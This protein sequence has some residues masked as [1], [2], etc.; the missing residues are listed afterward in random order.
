MLSSANVT[1]GATFVV[2]FEIRIAAKVVGVRMAD[3]LQ[4]VLFLCTGNSARSILAECILNR[5][6]KGQFIAHSAGSDPKGVVHPN[7]LALLAAK[8][9]DVSTLRS[10]S[11]E[12]FSS[13]LAPQMT[14]VFTVCGNAASEV[15]PVWPGHPT[16]AHWGVPDPAAVS[17]S[18]AVI[19]RAFERSYQLLTARISAF[20]ALPF[21]DL[22]AASLR[23]RLQRIG[24]ST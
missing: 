5:R 21:G 14:Y 22:D 16:T 23:Q 3:S 10:K 6:G 7:A 12:Q 15:C 20:C 1:C 19:A 17:G 8:R 13:D 11:W 18:D 24:D 4:H 2:F 9:Y